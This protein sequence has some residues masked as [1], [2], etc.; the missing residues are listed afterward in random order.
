MKKAFSSCIQIFS[1]IFLFL[2][3]FSCSNAQ[4]SKLVYTENDTIKQSVKEIEQTITW[5]QE[6]EG[7]VLTEVISRDSM[8]LGSDVPYGKELYKISKSNNNP[9][10][11]SFSDFGSLDISNLKISVK[12]K[13]DSFC[14][15]FASEEHKGASASFSGKY[16]F[17]YVFFLKDFEEGWTK[18][19][20]EELPE[21]TA[22]FNRWIYG[23]P[24]NGVDIIQIPVR[25]YADCGTIDITVF[26]NSS[27]NNEFYQI[28]IDRWKKV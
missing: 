3:F 23:Q 8:K 18:N 17:N 21:N 2:L 10:Y 13:L 7:E 11:P 22:Y 24:F 27:G 5:T 25:F 12:N 26:L 9:V 20:S 14:E 16:L 6:L 19:F 4:E 15:A 28:T 1:V